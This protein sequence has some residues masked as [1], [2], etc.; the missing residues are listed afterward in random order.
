MRNN[1]TIREINEA[2]RAGR[3]A[4][5]SLQRAEKKLQSARN[6][7]VWDMLGGGMI[8]TLVKHSKMGDA[9]N[10]MEDARAKLQIFQRELRDVEVPMEFRLEMGDFLTFADFFFDGLVADWMVQSR[11]ADARY[12]V[13]AAINKVERMLCTLEQMEEAIDVEYREV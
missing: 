3:E 4:L 2:Q 5:L 12:E 1:D 11:I 7:G 10:L 6:W 8:S 13:Q 9:S